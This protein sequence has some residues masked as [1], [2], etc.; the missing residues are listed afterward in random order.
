M[1]SVMMGL[2]LLAAVIWVGG[3]FFAYVVLRPVAGSQFEVPQRLR[4]WSTLFKKFF[5]WVWLA[6]LVLPITGVAIATR[7]FGGIGSSPLYVHGMFMLGGV[8]ILVFLY[9]YHVP[10]RQLK[11]AVVIENW[12]RG[13]E[14]LARIRKLVLLNL[15]LGLVVVSIA[16]AGRFLLG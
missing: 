11:E 16:G 5:S 14:L 8:M 4:L 12:S 15:G 2:H 3:M 9:L 7:L 6:I 13:G 10:F 1:L